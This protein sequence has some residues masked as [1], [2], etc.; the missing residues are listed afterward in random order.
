MGVGTDLD[1]INLIGFLF[2][3]SMGIL[4]IGL[5]RR[6]ALLPIILTA[7]YM[8]IGQQVMIAGL[9]FSIFRMV[10]LVGWARLIIRGEMLWGGFNEIDKLMVAWQVSRV[11]INT[12]QYGTREAF[13]GVSGYAFDAFGMYFLFRALVRSLEEV[14]WIIRL[15]SVSIIPLAVL[16]VFERSTTANLFSVFGGVGETTMI[17][18]EGRL[19]CQGPFR[20]PIMAGTFG[21]A[22]LPYFIGLWFQGPGFK[23]FSLAGI[24]AAL[25]IVLTAHSSGPLM[26]FL[27]GV[28]GMALWVVRGRMRLFRWIGVL[29]LVALHFVMK[30]PVWAIFGRLSE[31]IGGTGYHRT[32]LIT[33]TIE[34]FDEWWLLG[35]HN[36]GHWLPYALRLDPTMADITNQFIYE[37]IVGGILTIILFILMIARGFSAVG[38]FVH[39]DAEEILPEFRIMIWSLGVGLAAHV[40]SFMSVSYFDQNIVMF[41]LVLALTAMCSDRLLAEKESS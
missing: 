23:K 16:M 29:S 6:L 28:I 26:A 41:Y 39:F 11:T 9:H 4:L 14:P 13:I 20:H 12:L 17:D 25:L 19:R 1:T 22:L 32:M 33:A 18:E 31:M 40:V 7:G 3:V 5:P 37:G 35:T 2:A 8:T 38:R 10:I 15:I 30:D 36:T 21:A 34:H 24:G 27:S